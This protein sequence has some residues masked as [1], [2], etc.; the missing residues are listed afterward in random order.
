M[1]TWEEIL[2]VITTVICR[3]KSSS[4]IPR[5]LIQ[6]DQ[7]QK[8]REEYAISTSSNIVNSMN[9]ANHI[10]NPKILEMYFSD[11]LKHSQ[12]QN[13][14]KLNMKKM[15]SAWMMKYRFNHLK[16][17][18]P[19]NTSHAISEERSWDTNKDFDVKFPMPYITNDKKVNHNNWVARNKQSVQSKKLANSERRPFTDIQEY[20]EIGRIDSTNIINNNNDENYQETKKLSK[21]F[22]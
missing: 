4:K 10:H 13:K 22:K 16:I 20:R 1:I 17:N 5:V 18:K 12:K 15:N 2:K 19:K 11:N 14:L 6:D 8:V 7:I 3:N 21:L 9:G